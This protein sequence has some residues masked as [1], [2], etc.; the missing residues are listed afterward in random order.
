MADVP[1][2]PRV[3]RNLPLPLGE[4]PQ[5]L[6]ALA[7]AKLGVPEDQILEV[8]PLKV[9]LDARGTR[10]PVRRYTV[11]VWLSGEEPP[12]D[13]IPSVQPPTGMRRLVPGEAPIVVGTGPAG[14]WATLHL[15]QAGQPVILLERGGAL[16]DRHRSVVGL[17]RQGQLDPESNLCFGEG[18][19]G[20]YSDGKLYTRV[21]DPRVRRVYEDLVAF[22]AQP[23][24]LSEA[25]PHVGTNRL[26]RVL[27]RLRSH[28]LEAGCDVRFGAQVVGLLRASDGAVAGVRLADGTEL[29]SPAV[30]LATGHSA[31]DVY[32]SL[33]AAGGQLIRKPFAI[34]ARVEHPQE[35]IDQIQYGRW[36]GQED[37]EPATYALTAQI[38]G[39]GVYSFCMCPGGFVIPTPTELEHLNVNGMSNA[40]RGN[41]FANSA[42]VVT[43]EPDDFWLER[44]GDLDHLGPLAGLG[45]QRALERAAFDA[46]GR[47]YQAPAQR[48]TD[49]LE[50]RIGDL[51]ERTSYRPGITAADVHGL[52][53]ERLRGALGRALL[54]FDRM[55][56]GFVTREAILIGLE[57]TT[58][59][60]VR[61]ARDEATL[62]AVGLPRLYPCGEGAGY[63]GGIVSSAIDGIRVA[64]AWLA[65]RP[66]EMG[67]PM[68][69]L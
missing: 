20:T 40:R 12:V 8:R 14:L 47:T 53:P 62:E 24:I 64:E 5:A 1:T 19:A 34:G 28:L 50:A 23:D 45:L 52:I 11:Q 67:A 44:P 65:N 30:I 16:D 3:V 66:H 35:L 61:V 9:S 42:L 25:H 37:L 36:A 31:R 60:P 22:G 51:P 7:A 6:H 63:A 41:R 15:I 59:S 18:G 56:P 4:P 27:H 29:R 2:K 46:G 21:K 57:T 39:R 68:T 58:S 69:V 48:V 32:E 17:R 26:V 49:Y 54:R 43:V 10:R 33:H 13:A 38:G 55:M